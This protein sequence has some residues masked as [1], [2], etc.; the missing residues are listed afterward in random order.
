MTTSGSTIMVTDTDVKEH[1]HEAA[2]AFAREQEREAFSSSKPTR[3]AQ[4]WNERNADMEAIERYAK[5][6]CL[7]ICQRLF[8]RFP[9]EL[10]D[11][12]YQYLLP[13]G[14]TFHPDTKPHDWADHDPDDFAHR[15]SEMFRR[16]YFFDAEYVGTDV[17]QELAE[18]SYGALRFVF[19]VHNYRYPETISWLGQ[20]DRHG[21]RRGDFIDKVAIYINEGDEFSTEELEKAFGYQAGYS[22]RTSIQLRLSTMEREYDGFW[23]DSDESDTEAFLEDAYA[24]DYIK[25]LYPMIQGLRSAGHKIEIFCREGDSPRAFYSLHPPENLEFSVRDYRRWRTLCDCSGKSKSRRL[26]Y[27]WGN[28]LTFGVE[29]SIAEMFAVEQPKKMKR[30]NPHRGLL[31]HVGYGRQLVKTAAP[32]NRPMERPG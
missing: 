21:I 29:G 14:S 9:R 20:V 31:F 16:D 19:T 4:E 2:L 5:I 11:E 26:P 7:Q 25:K 32:Q 18:H 6:S 8:T 28:G 1:R 15:S 22:K 24:V 23:Q 10:R 12:I 30:K 13:Q 17:L 27:A 3:S